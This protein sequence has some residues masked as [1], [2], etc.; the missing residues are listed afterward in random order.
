[1]HIELER[2]QRFLHGELDTPAEAL[3]REHLAGC[4]DC[5]ASLERAAREEEEISARLTALD[6]P[7][8]ELRAR[9]LMRAPV[10]R[11][12][13]RSRWGRAALVPLILLG[14]AGGAYAFPGS[15]VPGWIDMLVDHVTGLVSAVR[16][17]TKPVTQDGSV[18]PDPS[19]LWIDPGSSSVVTFEHAQPGS[20]VRVILFDGDEVR[21]TAVDGAAAFT[22]DGSDL[23]IR[24]DGTA[25]RFEIRIPRLAP[26]VEIRVGDRVLFRKVGQ[27]IVTPVEPDSTDAWTLGLVDPGA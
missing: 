11:S 6:H 27:T 14:A 23:V 16:V 20:R 24:N 15:P 4:G 18:Q 8:P 9:D 21:A 26:L 1:M 17:S 3:V 25:T 12:R 22:A 5:R 10:R 13:R 19:G 2:M 7:R